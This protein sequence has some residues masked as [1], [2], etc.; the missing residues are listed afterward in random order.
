MGE[1][2]FTV[3]EMRKLIDGSIY[4]ARNSSPD[5]LCDKAICQRVLKEEFIDGKWVST[6]TPERYK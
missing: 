5:N 6:L 3:D 2:L 4:L 1:T